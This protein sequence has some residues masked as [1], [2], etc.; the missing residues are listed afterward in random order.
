MIG[1][2]VDAITKGFFYEEVAKPAFEWLFSGPTDCCNGV[3]GG[4]DLVQ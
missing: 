1:W 4:G 2:V 3:G